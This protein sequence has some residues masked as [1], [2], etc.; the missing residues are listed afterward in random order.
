MADYDKD[1]EKDEDFILRLLS[2]T[3]DIQELARSLMNHF[4]SR[5]RKEL[6]EISLSFDQN[7]RDWLVSCPKG[8]KRVGYIQSIPKAVFDLR[9]K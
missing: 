4:N 3:E 9:Q 6:G 2:E 7:M 5:Y 1:L 8:Q